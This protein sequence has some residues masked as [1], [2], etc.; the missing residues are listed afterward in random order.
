MNDTQNPLLPAD[1]IQQVIARIPY[2]KTLG[3]EAEYK[4]G[5]LTTTLRFHEKLIGN[6]LLPA[7]H[8]G[9]IGA[10]PHSIYCRLT[11]SFH[12]AADCQCAQTLPVPVL[13]GDYGSRRMNYDSHQ[14]H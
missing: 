6:P 3:M 14:L 7:L 12:G 9:A 1:R 13:L 10:S 4:G 11:C 2:A 5:E 8:G